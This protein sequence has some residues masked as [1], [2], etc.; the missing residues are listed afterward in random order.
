MYQRLG[1]IKSERAAYQQGLEVSERLATA[2]PQTAGLN[3]DLLVSYNRLGDVQIRLGES[4]AALAS[5]KQG[6]AISEQLAKADPDSAS[7]RD[8]LDG[9]L[10][11]AG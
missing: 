4:K 5:Y 2:D 9:Q 3:R 6:L 8:R 7:G 10:Q 1:D 11:Q